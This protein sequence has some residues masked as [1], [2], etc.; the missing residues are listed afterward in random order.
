LW[1][2]LLVIET[3]DRCLLNGAVMMAMVISFVIV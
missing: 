2:H 1:V 3:G